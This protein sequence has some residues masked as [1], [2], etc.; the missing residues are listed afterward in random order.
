MA[1]RSIFDNPTIPPLRSIIAELA[2]GRIQI[3]EFQRDFEWNDE[4][5]LNLLDSIARG[6]PI[7]SLLV[8]HTHEHEL[9]CFE[10]LGGF[11]LKKPSTINP[12]RYLL[13]GHQ[14]LSTLFS[15]LNHEGKRS[16]DDERRFAIYFDAQAQAGDRPFM[17]HRRAGAPPKHWISLSALM[18][19]RKRWEHTNELRQQDCHAEADRIEEIANIISDYQIPIIPLLSEDLDLVTDSF[20]RV[21]Q[22]GKPMQ[23]HYML[24]AL[25]YGAFPLR[26]RTTDLLDVLAEYGWGELGEQVITNALKV[27]LGL[28]VYRAGPREIIKKY[29]VDGQSQT[30]AVRL[31]DDINALQAALIKAIELFNDVGIAGPRALPYAYQLIAITEAYRRHDHLDDVGV[32]NVNRWIWLTTYK[33]YFTGMTGNRIRDAIEHLCEAAN[34]L[35]T[36]EPPT[37]ELTINPN[38]KYSARATRTKAFLLRLAAADEALARAFGAQGNEV[39]HKAHPKLRKID[40]PFVYVVCPAHELTSLHDAIDAPNTEESLE[41]LAR[42]RIPVEAAQALCADN[43]AGFE[44]IR[45][46]YLEDQERE[47]I[48]SLG[49]IPND[50][51][52]PDQL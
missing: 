25:A 9:T 8:W 35:A 27:S 34:G 12:Y 24:Q 48:T 11:A 5:R 42:H 13:D 3:P 10:T 20:V 30:D 29:R 22:S 46:A 17:L 49:L 16:E 32:A 43:A 36:P 21:N 47:F 23:E 1:Q 39:V 45:R 33:D 40:S 7:G 28:D 26:E 37:L 51:D 41:V 38:F 50:E 2:T 44:V 31:E 4:R 6:I 52:E 18:H 14:R 19:T 15:A